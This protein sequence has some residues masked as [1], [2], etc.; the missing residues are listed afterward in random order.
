[1]NLFYI[2]LTSFP[3]RKKK[4]SLPPQILELK[5][6]LTGNERRKKPLIALI[7]YHYLDFSS[8]PRQTVIDSDLWCILLMHRAVKFS[9][10]AFF[11]I[12]NEDDLILYTS[13]EC[14]KV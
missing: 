7:I 9:L 4:I 3:L 12:E 5:F 8:I 13:Q 1:M 6:S 14:F 11:H 10:T 2:N